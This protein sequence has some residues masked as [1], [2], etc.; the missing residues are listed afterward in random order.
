MSIA[1]A[2]SKVS[3]ADLVERE[4]QMQVLLR[5]QQLEQRTGA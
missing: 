2:K 4:I 3:K 1:G 5:K